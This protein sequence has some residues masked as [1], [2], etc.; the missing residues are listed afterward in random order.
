MKRILL[1]TILVAG[2]IFLMPFMAKADI[3]NQD[4]VV[5][6]VARDPYG[7]YI[8]NAQVDVYKQELDADGKPKPTTHFDGDTTDSTLGVA[9]LSFRNGSVLSDTYVFKVKI[10][11]N[12]DAIFWFYN[13][14]LSCGQQVTIEKTLSGIM[15]TLKDADG[16]TLKNTNFSVYSQLYSSGG[17]PLNEKNNHIITLNTGSS[18]QAKVYLPQGSVRGLNGYLSDHYAIELDRPNSVFTFYGIAV[19][20]GEITGLDYYLSAL[21]IRLQNSSGNAF[22]P[23]TKVEVYK[24]VVGASNQQEKGDRVGDFSI[25][26][27]GY[28]T[29]EVSPGLYV[30]GVQGENN[31]YQYFWDIE[32]E[33]GKTTEYTVTASQSWTPSEGSCQ[34]NSTFT[35][36]VDDFSGNSVAGLKYELYEQGLDNNGLPTTGS[37]VGGGT[38][39]SYGQGAISFRPDP[40]LGY[41]IKIWDKRSDLGEFWFY[42]AVK[43]VCDYNRNVNKIIPALRIVLRDQDGNLKRN[44]NFS[45]YAQ[46]YDADNNPTWEDRDLIA[47]LKTDSGGQ[48]VVYVSPYNTYRS[49]QT[50]V[51][52]IRAKDSS[53]N[54]FT[55][56]DIKIRADQDYSLEQLFSG[57]SGQL[58]DAFKRVQA[59]KEIRLYEQLDS[60]GVWILGKQLLSTKTDSSGNFRIDYPDGTYALAV[61]DQFNQENVFWNV[62][63]NSK[64]TNQSLMTNLTRLSLSPAQSSGISGDISF[65]L[66]KLVSNNNS[67]FYRDKEISNIQ[68][69]TDRTATIPLAMGPYLVVYT[70][71]SGTEFGQAFYAQN[72]RLEEV[73]LSISRDDMLSSGQTF[74]L[75]VPSYALS[76]YRSTSSNNTSGSSTGVA[77]A[78]RLQGRILLQVQDKGQAWYVNPDDN[79]RYYLGRPADAFNMMRTLS[80][81]IS[82]SDFAAL[83]NNPPSRLYGKILLKVED[84]GRAYYVDPVNKTLH[85]LGRPA[86]AFNIMRTLG[87]GITDSDLSQINTAN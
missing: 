40:R 42:D 38:L 34:N 48:A 70:S 67:T 87:L 84:N 33:S 61:S 15:F 23:N 28:G 54:Y 64:N 12:D 35:L 1:K 69:G 78:Q 76:S 25:G 45:L 26:S 72:G 79:K 4:T 37:K 5:D 73:V 20:D 39:D 41:A 85:Y 31:Q 63:A 59:N 81:G 6:F 44:Y 13:N 14:N 30:L 83:E 86:D 50:G 9:N 65:K 58:M 71:K 24:Q 7:T 36:S 62:Q 53:N 55:T 21:R 51:Y 19:T 82:N 68:L 8:P 18:G 17:S 60:A 22:P 49:N 43:F 75:G 47:N 52:A 16:S 3:C 66:Y 32:A 57:I 80:L 74:K 46:R 29:F 56:Y 10:I 2:V 11:N 27:D 77:M